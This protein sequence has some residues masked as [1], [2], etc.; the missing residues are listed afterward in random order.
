MNY[1]FIDKCHQEYGAKKRI[2]RCPTRRESTRFHSTWVKEMMLTM[3]GM[4][5]QVDEVPVVVEVMAEVHW[6]PCLTKH[7]NKEHAKTSKAMSS[8]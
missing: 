8:P 2:Q 5:G 1:K 3:E 6:Q 7:Q 4:A